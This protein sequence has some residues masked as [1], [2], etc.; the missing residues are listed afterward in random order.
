[1]SS[2]RIYSDKRVRPGRTRLDRHA[3]PVQPGELEVGYVKVNGVR[4]RYARSEG[5]GP[6]ILMCN[7]I[8]ANFE[9]LLPFVQALKGRRIVLFDVPGCGQSEAS[10]FWPSLKYYAKMAVG[11]MDALGHSGAFS[12]AGVSWGG[13]LAQQ[14]ARDYPARVLHLILMA[15]SAGILMIP[16]RISALLLMLTPIRYF[17]PRFMARNASLIYGGEMRGHLGRAARYASKA[18][19]PAMHA[20]F[21]Q[22]FAILRFTSLPWLHKI[23][24]PA[25]VLCGDDD[26][27]I[28]PANA[29]ILAALLHDSQ[30]HFIR[31][32]GHLFLDMQS[33][34]TARVVEQFLSTHAP[35]A[36]L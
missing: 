28:R 20:Y 34:E 25:L 16:G 6:P 3:A 29:H 13:G 8:G 27:L 31:G 19:P 10:L 21:Q 33:E 30:L 12:V 7:G 2:A 11:L 36:K 14:I 23:R 24:C 18:R 9:L 5:S 4:L 35:N 17:S 22:L 26:P 32:G 1:M 15:T